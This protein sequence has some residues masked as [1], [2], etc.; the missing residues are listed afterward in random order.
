LQ[1]LRARGREGFGRKMWRKLAS[2]QINFCD[3]SRINGLSCALIAL[4]TFPPLDT[5]P[6]FANLAP[7][8]HGA[9]ARAGLSLRPSGR[10]T[11]AAATA[12]TTAGALWRRA[13]FST[14][15]CVFED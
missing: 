11:A 1:G 3:R 14:T 15:D 5:I 6:P 7:S 10:N 13:R 2:R 9:N 12:E 8:R 4:P